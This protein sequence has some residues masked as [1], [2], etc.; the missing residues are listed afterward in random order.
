MTV[1]KKN[2]SEKV[3][4]KQLHK[5]PQGLSIEGGAMAEH[6]A[7]SK[8][9]SSVVYVQLSW[10]FGWC[11]FKLILKALLY[12]ALRLANPVNVASSTEG[13]EN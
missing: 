3:R 7:E 6:N 13:S 4:L 11:F 10:I 8:I 9:T 5:T 1:R 12:E 2:S